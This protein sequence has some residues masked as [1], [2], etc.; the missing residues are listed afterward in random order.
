MKNLDLEFSKKYE[1]FS[2]LNTQKSICYRTIIRFMYYELQKKEFLYRYEI[3]N[4][5]KEYKEF[6]EYTEDECYKDLDT[7]SEKGNIIRFKNDYS[8]IRT[9]EE[10]KKKKYR[11]QLTERTIMIENM[12]LKKFDKINAISPVLDKNLLTNLKK[13]LLDFTNNPKSFLNLKDKELYFWWNRIMNA[14]ENLNTNY[15]AYI[16]ELNSFEYEKTMKTDQFLLKKEKLKEYLEDFINGLLIES[17]EINK[18]LLKLREMADFTELL[19]RVAIEE[20]ET[21]DIGVKEIKIKIDNQIARLNNWFIGTEEENEVE[22]LRRNTIN[23]IRKI[24]KIAW[25]LIS[26]Q[27]VLFSRKESYKKVAETFLKCES[28]EEGHKLASLVFGTAKSAHIKGTLKNTESQEIV[29]VYDEKK[30]Q[31]ELRKITERKKEEKKIVIKDK[32][33]EKENYLRI[34]EMEIKRQTE[35]INK[36]IQNNYLEVEKLPKLSNYVRE[37]ILKYIKKG[38]TV[39]KNMENEKIIFFKD[40]MY[41]AYN[42]IKF[43]NNEYRLLLPKNEEDRC[44]MRTEEGN[45]DMPSIV[46]EFLE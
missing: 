1:E 20:S 31:F 14:F 33:I 34:R 2:Y 24:T 43:N 30:V 5:L 13:E 32:S 46:L 16:Q 6:E 21:N 19:D 11:Y 27:R 28:I 4:Y 44:V 8:E 7:L 25:Q 37:L 36:Y 22:I 26:K 18:I 42:K 15:K 12:L 39:P 23:I 35:E 9:L 3:Y 10:I 17:E 29:S 41:K 45:L 40:K 38:L